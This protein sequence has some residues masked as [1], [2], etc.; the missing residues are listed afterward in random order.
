VWGPYFAFGGTDYPP[1]SFNPQ[2]NDLYVCA[3]VTYQSMENVSPTDQSHRYETGGG[4]TTKGESG[5]VSALNVATNK[6][7]W[8]NVWQAT[9]QGTCY[10]GVLSTA[11]GLVFVGSMGQPPR[12]V[13]AQLVSKNFGGWFYAYDAKTGKQLFSYQNVSQITAPPITYTV[14][15]RQYIAVD[16]A[17]SVDYNSFLPSATADKLTVFWL[18]K[19]AGKTST[20]PGTT[21]P[22][23]GSG[24][25]KP[26]ATETLIGD[27]ANGSTLFSAQGCGSCHTLAAAG[28][29][30]T[31]GPNLDSTAPG[32]SA[33]VQ[34]VTNGGFNMPSYGAKLSSQQINDLASYVYKSTHA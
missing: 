6:L 22:G 25:A 27:P 24:G 10:S 18:G 29:K 28:S 16:M 7:A 31:A 9:T 4:W 26:P 1:M 17:A 21:T 14:G 3:N 19:S 12:A 13:T 8:Q 34:Q 2:T 11:G 32:Q 20:G 23:A 30:G 15:G 33:I 5:T